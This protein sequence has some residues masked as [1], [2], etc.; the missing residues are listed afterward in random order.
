MPEVSFKSHPAR[1][2][3][4]A[5]GAKMYD[6]GRPCTNGH[7]AMRMVSNGNCVDCDAAAQWARRTGKPVS[8][9]KRRKRAEPKPIKPKPMRHDR[10]KPKP[11][12]APMIGADL[13]ARETT[14]KL[15]KTTDKFLK[16]LHV[17]ALQAIRAEGVS[18]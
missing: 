1:A 9:W 17:E 10:S 7:H 12:E 2:A 18:R 16:L 13:D 11:D 5:A 14:R 4:K 15:V 6:P 3:A 8:Q